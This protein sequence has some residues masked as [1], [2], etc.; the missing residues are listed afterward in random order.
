MIHVSSSS[1]RLVNILDNKLSRKTLT[2]G[3]FAA[4]PSFFMLDLVIQGGKV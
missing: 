3:I 2:A 4:F 1:V